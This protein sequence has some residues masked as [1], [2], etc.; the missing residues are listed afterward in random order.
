MDGAR[1]YKVGTYVL[2]ADGFATELAGVAGERWRWRGE[3]GSG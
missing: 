1:G 3:V 2:W